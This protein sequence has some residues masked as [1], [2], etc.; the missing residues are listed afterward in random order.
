MLEDNGSGF[1]FRGSFTLEE[2]DLLRMGPASIK[3]RVRMLNGEM[4]VDSRPGEGVKITL[5]VPV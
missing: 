2:L 1:P 3:R 4:A 5:R